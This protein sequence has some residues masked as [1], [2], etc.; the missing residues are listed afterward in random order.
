MCRLEGQEQEIAKGQ[1]EEVTGIII[2]KYYIFHL[3]SVW[4]VALTGQACRHF[5]V[6]IRYIFSYLREQDILEILANDIPSRAISFTVN[7]NALS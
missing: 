3:Y 4:C 6:L 5:L 2:F 1:E 7:F